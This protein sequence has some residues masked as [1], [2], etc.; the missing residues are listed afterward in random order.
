ME[1][2]ADLGESWYDRIIGDDRGLMPY[3]DACNIACGFHGGD[4]LTI[5]H[6][7]DLALENGVTIGAHPS[8]PDRQNFGRKYLDLGVDRLRASILYQVAA[9]QGMVF[10]AGGKLRHLKAHGALYHFTNRDATAA[11]TLV[12]VMTDFDIPVLFGPPAGELRKAANAKGIL[13]YAE[14][15]ADRR[16][17]SNL[18]LVSRNSPESSIASIDE[19]VEQVSMMR[20][21]GVVR[22]V[23]GSVYPIEVDTICLHGDHAGAVEK[24]MAIRALLDTTLPPG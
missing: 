15:F 16:Y 21:E 8:F 3:L 18:Q 9:L 10:A 6:T 24:A 5:Q 13:F 11:K 2:N 17:D 20:N 7:I 19:A 1:L 14:G 4:A 12:G 23:Q 22:S